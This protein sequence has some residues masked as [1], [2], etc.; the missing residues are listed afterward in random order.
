[1][2]T[3]PGLMCWHN[4]TLHLKAAGTLN[5]VPY[6]CSRLAVANYPIHGGSRGYATM[7]KL[8]GAGWKIVNEQEITASYAEQTESR[9]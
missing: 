7:Q 2:T 4:G 3:P 1:M 8:L 9:I 5:W 6:N